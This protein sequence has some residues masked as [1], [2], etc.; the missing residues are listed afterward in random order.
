MPNKRSLTKRKLTVWIPMELHAKF[1][2][3][4]KERGMNV[5]EFLQLLMAEA[6]AGQSITEAQQKE[7]ARR[8]KCAAGSSVRAHAEQAAAV[9]ADALLTGMALTQIGPSVVRRGLG[10]HGVR[11]GTAP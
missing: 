8:M 3:A 1:A 7:M 2:N 4:A 6:A 11:N 5:T 10:L 9:L